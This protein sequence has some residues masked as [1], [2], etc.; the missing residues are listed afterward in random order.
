MRSLDLNIHLKVYNTLSRNPSDHK[1][2][3]L[4]YENI[5]SI[6]EKLYHLYSWN[7]YEKE[8]KSFEQLS[9][10]SVI[11]SKWV[12][13]ISLNIIIEDE[14]RRTKVIKLSQNEPLQ[15]FNRKNLLHVNHVI[16][17]LIYSIEKVITFTFEKY[18]NHY[19][20]ILTILLGEDKA[21]HNW[22]TYLEYGTQNPIE[23]GLQSL[24]LSRHTSH[25]IAKSPKLLKCID[26]DKA[27]GEVKGVDKNSLLRN[28]KT[29]SLEFD[30]VVSML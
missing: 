7:R 13:G 17:N 9:Y 26:I 27:S 30:E 1:L 20:K 25:S 5:K 8:I 3:K 28:I 16:D 14:L 23:I 29:N 18:F 11:M 21:G 12:S 15:N 19:H 4:D 6:L 10:Y 24:G 22:S 2:P